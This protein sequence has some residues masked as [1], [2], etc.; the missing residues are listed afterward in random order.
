MEN[1]PVGKHASSWREKRV[2]GKIDS[3]RQRCL[4]AS[5]LAYFPSK[6]IAKENI[7]EK[8]AAPTGKISFYCQKFIENR[9]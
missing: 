4:H 7:Y 9:P 8:I 6:I 2:G 1:K 5:L 3:F